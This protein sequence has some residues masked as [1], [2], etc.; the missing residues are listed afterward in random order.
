MADASWFG[1]AQA[2][3]RAEHRP[4]HRERQPPVR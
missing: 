4:F 2:W 3:P 1:Q